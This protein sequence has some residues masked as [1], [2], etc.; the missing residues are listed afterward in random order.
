MSTQTGGINVCDGK[1]IDMLTCS[2]TAGQLSCTLLQWGYNL[3]I[4]LV[5]QAKLDLSC[6]D[7][8]SDDMDFCC[9]LAKEESVLVMPGEVTIYH[10]TLFIFFT[11]TSKKRNPK[12]S[13][14]SVAQIWPDVHERLVGSALGM[15]D[16]LRIT[17]AV[18]MPSLEDGLERIKS[19][20]ERH[21][22]MEA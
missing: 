6:L 16:C 17:F 19:F 15:K 8:F 12:R 10:K 22:K 1:E 9:K 5:F 2:S 4:M 18:N 20:C 11:K 21:G 3:E 7:G 14:Y 13:C